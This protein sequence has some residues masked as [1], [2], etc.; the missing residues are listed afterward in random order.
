[1]LAAMA[2]ISARRLCARISSRMPSSFVTADWN[3]SKTRK[4]IRKSAATTYENPYA[5]VKV[6]VAR[7][8]QL[9][10]VSRQGEVEARVC[11]PDQSHE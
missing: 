6:P 4:K 3:S 11:V 8:D 10:A 2:F 5:A 7:A 1:M 9:S